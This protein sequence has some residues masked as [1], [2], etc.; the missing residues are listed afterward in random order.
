[1]SGVFLPIACCFPFS[2]DNP[3]AGGGWI[4]DWWSNNNIV[5][6]IWQE[7]LIIV[8]FTQIGELLNGL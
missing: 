6:R 5:V 8:K 2:G 1:M 7:Q 4:A 3:V